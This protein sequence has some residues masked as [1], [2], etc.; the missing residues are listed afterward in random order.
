MV[1]FHCFLHAHEMHDIRAHNFLLGQEKGL[2][3]VPVSKSG[4]RLNILESVV[5]YDPQVLAL[6]RTLLAVQPAG[7]L[8]TRS[9]A[10][11]RQQFHSLTTHSHLHFR[12]FSIHRGGATA[13]FSHEWLMEKTL[14]RGRWPSTTVVRQYITEGLAQLPSLR[15]S[16]TVAH[17]FRQ[18]ATV[19]AGSSAR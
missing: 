10:A 5:I 13:F 18:S 4:R 6:A 19:F 1:G 8:W 15:W 12:P 16:S 17:Q 11:F 7:L 9:S 2:L 14:I 3:Q